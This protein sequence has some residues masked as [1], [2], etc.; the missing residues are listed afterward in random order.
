MKCR[1]FSALAALALTAT[2]TAQ[3]ASRFDETRQTP[4][5]TRT[6]RAVDGVLR[7]TD[8]QSEVAL[9]GVNYYP[10]FSLDYQALKARGIDIRAAIREDLAHFQRLGIHCLRLHTFDREFSDQDGNFID[11]E[12]VELLDYLI[13]ECGKRNL[14]VV[15]TPICWWGSPNSTPFPF[16]K[17]YKHIRDM[18]S[19]P[20]AQE[21]QAR[22]LTQFGRHVNRYT[23]KTYAED[24]I[25]PVFELINEPHYPKE[26]TEQQVVDYINK[27][28]DAMRASGTT[29]PI[30]YSTWKNQHK[31]CQQA[32]I[33]GVTHSWYPSGLVNK[34][35]LRN[36]YLSRV[37]DFPALR[38]PELDKRA[39][40][41]YEFDCADILNPTMYPAMARTFRSVGVQIAAMFQYDPLRLADVNT[42][43]PTHYLNLA[44]TP[45]KAISF[46]I[47][48]RAF[49][50]IPR[51]SR[52]SPETNR[53]FFDV[54][55]SHEQRLAELVT[56]TEFLY[57]N[58]TT[59]RPPAPEKLTTIYGCGSSTVVSSTGNGTY[60]LDRLASG[61][62]LFEV[63]PSIATC[64]D[65][66]SF[67]Q[68][69]KIRY[70][71]LPT[72]FTITLPDLGA[73]ATLTHLDRQ[74]ETQT[75]SPGKPFS[76]LPGQYRLTRHNV[77]PTALLP[78]RDFILPPD[79]SDTSPFLKLHTPHEYSLCQGDLTITAN[80]FIPPDARDITLK[81]TA[82]GQQQTTDI[83]LL[84]TG[85]DTFAA[86]IPAQIL[87][88]N[89][90]ISVH[91]QVTFH[92]GS[93]RLF[94][95]NLP[96]DAITT[97]VEA[98]PAIL[99]APD[100]VMT[101]RGKNGSS[102]FMPQTQAITHHASQGYSREHLS[103]GMRLKLTHTLPPQARPNAVR[104]ELSGSV[105]TPSVE[106][107]LIQKNGDAFGCIIPLSNGIQSITFPL[108]AF[109]ALWNTSPGKTIQPHDITQ[110]SLITGLWLFPHISHKPHSFTLHKLE[111]LKLPEASSIAILPADT[112]PAILS[113]DTD[114]ILPEATAT[115]NATIVNASNAPQDK[116][117]CLN[118][119]T[120]KA[121]RDHATFRFQPND[122]YSFQ[123]QLYRNATAI[124]ITA[125]ALQPQT[126]ACEIVFI[127]RDGLPWGRKRIPLTTQWQDITIPIGELDLFSHWNKH[128]KP[129]RPGDHLNPANI[130]AIAIT[131]GKFLYGDTF[132]MPH[133]FEIKS[134]RAKFD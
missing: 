27:L 42:S 14:Y 16:A 73:Q 125:R 70:H 53:T 82:A 62:W 15:L 129:R 80:G 75:V 113:F 59:T 4:Q 96:A 44:C 110:V 29:K 89:S 111:F 36:D 60:F 114:T 63:Y 35:E 57:A 127:E 100:T 119:P 22:F 118:A 78:N 108:D 48:A 43:W 50:R 98:W 71:H 41:I 33:D 26:M 101:T 45:G 86:T 30:F 124:V 37:H 54:R 39:K 95:G 79:S 61:D 104:I 77:S 133:A 46:A 132:D 121:A 81:V 17:R 93:K 122:A 128:Y 2:A 21:Q 85:F 72:T 40:M 55:L 90:R 20:E 99:P 115:A 68:M 18:V 38:H 10:P 58:D 134:I 105:N 102:S 5:A 47:A 107:G 34:R 65:P 131:F 6:M 126:N 74:A 103:S 91:A 84:R 109:N 112:L 106:L 130:G 117:L 116:V 12:H 23:G 52:F 56:E 66:F 94:P 88:A 87:Q 64:K 67:S 69:P 76:L 8:D 32:R 1:L 97:H 3:L 83:P 25:I 49:Q 120:F 28:A 7:W 19:R 24:P 123:P 92:D 11:N 51:N 13:A 9:F 31:A